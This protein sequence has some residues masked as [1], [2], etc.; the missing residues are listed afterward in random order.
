MNSARALGQG[1][2]TS[3]LPRRRFRHVSP[4]IKPKAI[5]KYM[6]WFIRPPTLHS[7]GSVSG[8]RGTRRPKGGGGPPRRTPRPGRDFLPKRTVSIAF[9]FGKTL[10]V[11]QSFLSFSGLP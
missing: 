4:Q 7:K 11:L 1:K 10:F 9:C 5:I 2:A 3:G 6:I 8:R